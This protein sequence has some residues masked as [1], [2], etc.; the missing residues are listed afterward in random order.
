MTK[1]CNTSYL[2]VGKISPHERR[3]I[4]RTIEEELKEKNKAIQERIN[5]YKN[6]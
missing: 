4:L 5:R 6:N 3:I 2:D 1:Y